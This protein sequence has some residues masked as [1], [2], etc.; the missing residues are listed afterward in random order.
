MTWIKTES[1]KFI[2][3]EVVGVQYLATNYSRTNPELIIFFRGGGE[4]K[5]IGDEAGVLWERF[6]NEEEE[7]KN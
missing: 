5:F 7:S 2:K 1:A 3:D 6:G 4:M